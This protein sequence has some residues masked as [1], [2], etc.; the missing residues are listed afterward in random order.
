MMLNEL[1]GPALDGVKE[2]FGDIHNIRVLSSGRITIHMQ[3][4]G[5]SLAGFIR[6]MYESNPYFPNCYLISSFGGHIICLAAVYETK[7]LFIDVSSGEIMDAR[8]L[9]SEP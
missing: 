9:I 6:P 5:S 3:R 8:L 4:K 1:P 2:L 7:V